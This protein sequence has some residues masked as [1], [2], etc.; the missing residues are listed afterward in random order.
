MDGEAAAKYITP[1]GVTEAEIS[2]A[3]H[4]K[5]AAHGPCRVPSVPPISRA[6]PAPSHLP[7]ASRTSRKSYG[8]ELPRLVC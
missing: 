2:E 7:G 6:A 1:L 4:G 3:A 5:Q 8:R